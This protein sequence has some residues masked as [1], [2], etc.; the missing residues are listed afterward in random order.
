MS[1]EKLQ[2][3]NEEHF[4]HWLYYPAQKLGHIYDGGYASIYEFDASYPLEA[5][6]GEITQEIMELIADKLGMGILEERLASSDF[7][8]ESDLN[9]WRIPG[10]RE[11][12]DSP[13]NAVVDT[14]PSHEDFCE[15]ADR[16]ANL[17]IQK[18]ET[19]FP[20]IDPSEF[21]RFEQRVADFLDNYYRSDF[22]FTLAKEDELAPEVVLR[23][24]DGNGKEQ[25]SS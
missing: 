23:S 24:E 3:L 7:G 21:R 11:C 8:I 12:K 25:L 17:F 14:T 13:E 9:S 10:V 5:R 16:A 15:L 22:N 1:D 4:S 20:E 18:L 2:E 6:S 19:V